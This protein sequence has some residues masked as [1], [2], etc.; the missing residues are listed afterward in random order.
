MQIVFLIWHN[1]LHFK[2]QGFVLYDMGELT[3]NLNVRAFKL[4]FGGQV[5][6]VYSGYITQSKN[7]CTITRRA[8]NGGS[9]N[10]N[11]G[12]SRYFIRF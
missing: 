10:M 8:K 1:L 6:N 4:S 11:G 2:E 12:G 9:S 3:D 7:T 5:V